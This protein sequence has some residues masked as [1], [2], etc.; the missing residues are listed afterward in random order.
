MPYQYSLAHLTALG[1]PPPELAYVAARAGYDYISPRLIYM[2]LPGDNVD[3]FR[4][5]SPISAISPFGTTSCIVSIIGGISV[6]IWAVS[7]SSWCRL[8]IRLWKS[9]VIV[10]MPSRVSKTERIDQHIGMS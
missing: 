7:R 1:C 10:S 9:S 8:G 6:R 3:G 5:G 4:D 2:G